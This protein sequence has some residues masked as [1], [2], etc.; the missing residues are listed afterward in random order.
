M[1]YFE[2]LSLLAL[3]FTA[4]LLLAKALSLLVGHLRGREVCPKSELLT[5]VA[6]AG[7]PLRNTW[8]V[9]ALCFLLG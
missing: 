5:Q 6:Q 8:F 7:S 2:F 1:S 4:C 9:I 3:T